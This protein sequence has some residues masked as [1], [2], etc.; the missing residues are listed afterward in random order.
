MHVM[1]YLR[2]NTTRR[3]R[4]PRCARLSLDLLDGLLDLLLG[5]GS[6][7]GLLELIGLSLILQG[8]S[9]QIARASDLE[10]DVVTVLLDAYV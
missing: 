4:N 8:Q 10:L 2:L 1:R 7:E 6:R 3:R 9:V 5:E